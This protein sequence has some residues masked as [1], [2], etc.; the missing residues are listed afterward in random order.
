MSRIYG[1]IAVSKILDGGVDTGCQGSVELPEVAFATQDFAG[2]G[3]MGTIAL[4]SAGQFEDMQTTIN[5][6]GISADVLRLHRPGTHELELRFK[7][8]TFMAG[9]GSALRLGKAF[10][11]GEYVSGSLGSVE[12]GAVAEGSAVYAVH[13]MQLL[14]SDG[15]ELMLIDKFAHQ[16]RVLGED[17]G[18]D[19]YD[20]LD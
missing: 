15:S 4:P 16:Y 9:S 3:I 20:G 10:L 6:R 1:A 7:Q 19:I 8:S 17:H 2:P 5:T 11:T 13:R 18:A 12:T 14:D